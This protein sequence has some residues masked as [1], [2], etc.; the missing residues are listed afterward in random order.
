VLESDEELRELQALLDRTH[1]AMS[2][3]HMRDIV[4][5]ERRL[6]ARQVADHLQGTRHVAFA[7]VSSAG[8]PM[9]RPLDGVFI[10]GRFTVGSSATSLMIRHLRRDP[11]CSVLYMETEDFGVTVHGRAELIPEGHADSGAIGEV[12]KGIYGSSPYSWGEVVLARI[13][14]QRM[15]TYAGDPS[16]F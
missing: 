1:E 7:T 16:R 12:W 5:A 3:Q 4:K 9:V 11:R 10:H 13:H 8:A 14:A 2:T 15:W 6:N